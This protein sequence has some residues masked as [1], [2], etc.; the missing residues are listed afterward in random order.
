MVFNQLWFT[1][2][3]YLGLC[4]GIGAPGVPALAVF[5]WTP[6]AQGDNVR[7]SLARAARLLLYE[8]RVVHYE[9]SIFALC[10]SCCTL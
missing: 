7:N 1:L 2:I 10:I 3:V 8:V 9:L 4:S 5:L 6:S